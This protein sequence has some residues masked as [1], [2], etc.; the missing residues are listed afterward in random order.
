MKETLLVDS[1]GIEYKNVGLEQ[2]DSYDDEPMLRSFNRYDKR[3][4]SLL[5]TFNELEHTLDSVIA[6]MISER[7]DD[8][9][10]RIILDLSFMQK[11]ELYNRLIKFYLVISDK[12]KELLKLKELING[13]RSATRIRNIV[14]HAKWMSLDEDSFVRSKTSLDDNAYINFKYYKLTP[15]VLYNLERKISKVD[16][17]L[18]NFADS[19][20][21]L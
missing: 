13:L 3:I 2:F 15:L 17:K 7:S 14:A 21:L 5:I 1:N 11:V 6:F 16:T 9:G 4:G 20:N 18:Y 12:K 19:H 10:Y 8:D